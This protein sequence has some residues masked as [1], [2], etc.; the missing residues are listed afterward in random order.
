M[1]NS[2]FD[3]ASADELK[4]VGALLTQPIGRHLRGSPISV[5]ADTTLAQAVALMQK[6]RIGCLLVVDD[7]GCLIG[8]F[9]ER[10]LLNRV[11]GHPVDLAVAR[12]DK[13]M[14]ANPETLAADDRLAWALNRMHVGGYRHVP[15][16]S[17][18][19]VPLGVLS[20]KDIVDDIVE[21]FPAEIQ[22]LPPDPSHESPQTDGGA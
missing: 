1:E 10:D 18:G 19:L 15:I 2:E 21:L 7:E 11:V 8:I 4:A 16:I 14:T 13:Y 22:N 20:V 5:S 17:E 9:T 12:I 6:R 3:D